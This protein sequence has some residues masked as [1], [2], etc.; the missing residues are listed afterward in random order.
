MNTIHPPCVRAKFAGPSAQGVLKSRIDWCVGVLFRNDTAR[1]GRPRGHGRP[2]M[3]RFPPVSLPFFSPRSQSG[4]SAHIRSCSVFL[5]FLSWGPLGPSWRYL[6]P[7]WGHLGAIL[8]PLG[9]LLGP[10]WGLLGPSGGHL[11]AIWGPSGGHLGAS[12]GHLGAILG[13]SWAILAP[14][15]GHLGFRVH[16]NKKGIIFPFAPQSQARRNAR[17]D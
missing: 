8:G 1:A 13:P 10:S 3:L 14:S 17:S 16:S 4:L 6:G 7:S 2:N 11:G 5:C 12:R 15:W 9:A